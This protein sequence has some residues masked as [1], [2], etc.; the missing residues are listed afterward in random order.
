LCD[1]VITR[2]ASYTLLHCMLVLIP[3]TSSTRHDATKYLKI[4]LIP[5]TINFINND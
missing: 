1:H 3:N 4:Y 2:F 5:D